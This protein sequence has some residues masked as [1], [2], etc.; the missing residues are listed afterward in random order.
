MEITFQPHRHHLWENASIKWED[1]ED[2][3]LTLVRSMSCTTKS[4]SLE[5]R[6]NEMAVFQKSVLI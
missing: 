3:I 1:I 5:M 4:F 2:Q 6:K